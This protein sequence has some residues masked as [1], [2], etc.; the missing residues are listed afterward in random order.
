MRTRIQTF[1][2]AAGSVISFAEVVFAPRNSDPGPWAAA[3]LG[4]VL[5]RRAII[6]TRQSVLAIASGCFLATILVAGN[7]RFL[8]INKPLWIALIIVAGI[9]YAFGER[10]EKLWA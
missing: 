9:G 10:I 2:L 8:E 3:V 4:I 1:L 5:L 6:T 7:H